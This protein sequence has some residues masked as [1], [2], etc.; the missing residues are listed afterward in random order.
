MHE[1]SVT[2]S[3]LEIVLKHAGDAE[4][5]TDI[6]LVIGQL[7]SFIDDSIQFFWDNISKDTVASGAK[8]NFR[9]IPAKIVCQ[10]CWQKNI[11]SKNFTCPDCGSNEIKIVSGDEF[12]IESIEIDEKEANYK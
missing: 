2:Q 11:L 12:Y 6:H 1:L 7:S 3:I 4:R 8:L 10:D 5:V 9:R